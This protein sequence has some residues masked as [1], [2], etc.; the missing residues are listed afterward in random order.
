MMKLA[1]ILSLVCQAF[2]FRFTYPNILKNCES[3]KVHFK[4]KKLQCNN[5][6]IQGEEFVTDTVDTNEERS[7][8]L[9]SDVLAYGINTGK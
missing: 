8:I 4:F 1:L 2:A 5:K 3:L 7:S 6:N 9:A